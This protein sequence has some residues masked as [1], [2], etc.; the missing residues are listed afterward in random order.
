MIRNLQHRKHKVLW[1][2][3]TQRLVQRKWFIPDTAVII[4]LRV[5]MV[6]IVAF[7]LFPQVVS[8]SSMVSLLGEQFDCFDHMNCF[9]H[10]SD[11]FHVNIWFWDELWVVI[12]W[13]P[14][15]ST[16]SQSFCIT[17]CCVVVSYHYQFI[18]LLKIHNFFYMCLNLTFV[19]CVLSL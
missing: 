17:E 9:P 4:L 16:F 12:G 6:S 2:Y 1:V 8:D 5:C 7:C 14:S 19:Q 3:V 18:S 15:V 10:A 13:A 11:F